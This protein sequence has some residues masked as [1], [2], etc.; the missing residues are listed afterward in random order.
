[1]RSPRF[2]QW[3]ADRNDMPLDYV[4]G[5]WDSDVAGYT[6][7]TYCVEIAWAA[8]CEAINGVAA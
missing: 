8:W 4:I 6:S 5:M 1:M 7:R 2:E 3:F